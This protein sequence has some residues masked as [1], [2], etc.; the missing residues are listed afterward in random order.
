MRKPGQQGPPR[1]IV[2]P[3][4]RSMS[5]STETESSARRSEASNSSSVRGRSIHGMPYTSASG[6]QSTRTESRR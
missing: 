1:E 5:S 3:S 2:T 4:T 6:V